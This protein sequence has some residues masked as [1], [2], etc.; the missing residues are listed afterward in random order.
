MRISREIGQYKK[1]HRMSVVQA[2]RYNDVIRTRVK[3]GEEM[4]MSA[5]F[6]KTILLAIHDE[7]VRQQIEVLNDRLGK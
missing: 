6:M 4:G 2:N 7:S 5:D 3:L 1:E